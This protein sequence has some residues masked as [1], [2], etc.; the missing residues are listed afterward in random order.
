MKFVRA[1]LFIIAPFALIALAWTSGSLSDDR[2]IAPEDLQSGYAFQSPDTQALQDDPFA[3]PGLLWVDAGKKQWRRADRAS[4]KACADCHGDDGSDMTGVAARYPAYDERAQSLLNLEQRINLCRKRH[5]DADP[6]P[7]KSEDLLSLTAFLANLSNGMPADVSIDGAARPY[8]EAGRAYYYQRRGHLNLACS[9]CH[10][11]N[12]GKMLRG[13]RLSQGH[14]NGYPTYRLEWQTIGSLHRR[15]RFCDTG[16]R[17]EPSDYGSSEYVSLEL[18]LA[19]RASGLP[20]ETPAV[21][22]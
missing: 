3:N 4:G 6:L 14:G 16:V 2:A 13:D 15:L 17:A 19:W 11:N 21:R 8:F 22:R 18:F 20:I 12:W 1:S 5:Q 9:H 10:E 7:Y